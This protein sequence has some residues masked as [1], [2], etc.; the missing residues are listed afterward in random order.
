MSIYTIATIAARKHYREKCNRVL[1]SDHIILEPKVSTGC[2]T[3][4]FLEFHE[5]IPR[6]RRIEMQRL[7]QLTVT[8]EITNVSSPFYID[9][10]SLLGNL[11]LR[12]LPCNSIY[13]Y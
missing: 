5:R 13:K 12:L 8:C 9:R 3:P 6:M 4:V 2:V 1:L 10:S 11:K 7:Q